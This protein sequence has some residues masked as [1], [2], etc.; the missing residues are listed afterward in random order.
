MTAKGIVERTRNPNRPFQDTLLDKL[1]GKWK[2]TGKIAGRKIKHSCHAEWVLNHQFL[3]VHFLDIS[4][5]SPRPG[6][7]SSR[8]HAP[9]EATV[10]IGY[11]NLSERYGAHWS[12]I[13]GGRFAETLGFGTRRGRNSMLFVF[14]YPSGPLH[15]GFTWNPGK[16]GWTI[17][18]EQKDDRGK[19][20]L[21]ASEM[22]RRIP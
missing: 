10:F 3:K 15:N 7:K 22:L 18:I 21:F 9:Y 12:D 11:D 5:E 19:W 13:F 16:R 4:N 17:L 6:K 14:E 8:E 20:T 2:V 1:I